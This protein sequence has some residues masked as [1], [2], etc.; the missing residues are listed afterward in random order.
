MSL[1]A[2]A[3]LSIHISQEPLDVSGKRDTVC[4]MMS[5]RQMCAQCFALL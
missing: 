1:A 3:N 4:D 2:V 5:V